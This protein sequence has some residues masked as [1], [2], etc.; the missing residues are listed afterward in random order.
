MPRYRITVEYF[1]RG[2]VGW[3]RQANGPSVQQALEE[4][5]RSFCGESPTVYGAGRTDAGV[6]ALG[7]VAHFDLSRSPAPETVRDAMNYHLRPAAISVVEAG[8]VDDAFDARRSA[9]GRRYLY[10]IFNRRAPPALLEGRVWHV[11]RPLDA[12]AMHEA[13][14]VL[15]GRHDFSTFRASL[16]QAKSPVK[17]LDALSVWREGE[18]IRIAAAARSFLHNQVRILVGTLKLVGEGK[19]TASDLLAALQ[20]RNRAEGGP[21]APPE[22]LYLTEVV[23]P[24]SALH[25]TGDTGD[26]EADREVEED[27][28]DRGRRAD[29][30]R[31]A[32]DEPLEGQDP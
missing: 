24:G 12:E 17:T 31:S 3:Q 4:A 13:A 16:C 26:G 15:I 21:T 19:W 11:A 1:G 20:A 29:V 6:H 18:E 30:E 23:Y 5:I 9:T 25:R 2:L 22:G 28:G 32:G 8:R 7:Q 27:H 14:Q 10:R